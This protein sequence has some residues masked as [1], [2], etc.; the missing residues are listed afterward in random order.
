MNNSPVK[1]CKVHAK[2]SGFKALKVDSK[3]SKPPKFNLG[4]INA[5]KIIFAI[6][7]SME[8]K[9]M[10]NFLSQCTYMNI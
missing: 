4:L 9:R 2:L 8:Y 6:P 1:T 5:Y 7:L 3:V 10:R